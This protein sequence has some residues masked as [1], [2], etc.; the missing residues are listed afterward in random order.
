MAEGEEVIMVEDE[1]HVLCDGQ[2]FA[3]FDHS[4]RLFVNAERTR[5]IQVNEMYK[6]IPDIRRMEWLHAEFPDIW[7]GPY[8]E[9]QVQDSRNQAWMAAIEMRFGGTEANES[10]DPVEKHL[11]LIQVTCMFLKMGLK[12][13][14]VEDAK[15]WVVRKQGED[16]RGRNK[17][18][19]LST[20][21]RMGNPMSFKPAP[22]TM[23]PVKVMQRNL[24]FLAIIVDR[25]LACDVN[26]SRVV[27]SVTEE[28]LGS[29]RQGVLAMESIAEACYR[30]IARR[31][32]KTASAGETKSRMMRRNGEASLWMVKVY[33]E[34]AKSVEPG[35]EQWCTPQNTL[36]KRSASMLVR[37][38][39]KAVELDESQAIKMDESQAIKMDESQAIK[40]DEEPAAEL[41]KVE[42]AL[43]R[44]KRYRAKAQEPDRDEV[45][46]DRWTRAAEREEEIAADLEAERE[47]EIAEELEAELENEREDELEAELD[48][49]D[50]EVELENE[51]ENDAADEAK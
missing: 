33:E 49:A 7:L 31:V 47:E 21:A 34:V 12:A 8:R 29:V 10:I 23:E 42:L 46:V 22:K 38:E 32:L 44:A 51:R 6:Q 35:S 3:S 25:R 18:F 14:A 13:V 27:R 48:V 43:H 37:T 30:Y 9:V 15:F 1:H 45:E 19:M 28:S 5:M 24:E 36:T 50:R 17:R 2:R 41:G 39:S 40:I 16:V 26:V 11:L 20:D 4:S